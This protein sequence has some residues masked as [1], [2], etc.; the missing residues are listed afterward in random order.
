VATAQRSV[1]S[2]LTPAD[3]KPK[4]VGILLIGGDRHQIDP[5]RP[6][7]KP[8]LARRRTEQHARQL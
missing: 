5:H 3:A 6:R 7:A 1:A 8:P 2:V 4:S